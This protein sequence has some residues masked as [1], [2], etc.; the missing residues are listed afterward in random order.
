MVKDL[1]NP[2]VKLKTIQFI[3]HVNKDIEIYHKP[4]G[5]NIYTDNINKCKKITISGSLKVNCIL[6]IQTQDG[7]EFIIGYFSNN[8]FLM[9]RIITTDITKDS[10]IIKM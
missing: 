4:K 10:I 9:I 6:N 7:D 3:N 2:E 8:E 5:F 1:K